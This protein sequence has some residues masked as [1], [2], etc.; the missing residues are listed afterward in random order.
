MSPTMKN[1]SLNNSTLISVY[2]QKSYA[3][4]LTL[5]ILSH[6]KSPQNVFRLKGR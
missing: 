2:N 3:E 4:T 1:P 5:I 6:I